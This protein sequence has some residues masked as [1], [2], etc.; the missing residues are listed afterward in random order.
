MTVTIEKT[1][2]KYR[3]LKALTYDKIRMKQ[4]RWDQ[5]NAAVE[6]MLGILKPAVLLDCPVGTGRFLQTAADCGVAEYIGVDASEEM[7]TLAHR[8]ITRTMKNKMTVR[9]DVGDA[10][11]HKCVDERVDVTLCIRFLDLID[12][13]AMRAVMREMMRVTRRCIILTIRLGDSYIAKSNT[14]THDAKRFRS[15]VR[16]DGW[17]IIEEVPVF[18]AGWF[19]MR[20]EK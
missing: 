12:E 4:Q 9:L 10:R 11:H 6:R 8:K 7:L 19:I 2:K 14:A 20:I 3:G 18:N 1:T 17:R 5:E 13:T 15:L 16:K